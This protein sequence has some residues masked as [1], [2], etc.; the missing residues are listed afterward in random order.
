MSNQASRR[1]GSK[2]CCAAVTSN[3]EKFETLGLIAPGDSW[4]P[5]L[6]IGELRMIAARVDTEL[7]FFHYL[8]RRGTIEE[9]I[10]FHGDEQDLLSMYL[11]NGFQLD[12]EALAGRPVMFGMADAPVRG[13]KMPR[14]DRTEFATPGVH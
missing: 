4:A 10:S 7:S 1:A 2:R 14:Q 5:I 11:V 3:R 9:L 13:P 8:T 12:L 6:S